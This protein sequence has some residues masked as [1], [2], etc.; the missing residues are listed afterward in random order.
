MA[1]TGSTNYVIQRDNLVKASLRMI[2]VGSVD[3]DPTSAEITN[4]VEALNIMLK[5]WQTA[6][7]QLW[8]VKEYE[9]TPVEGTYKYSLG[10]TNPAGNPVGVRPMRI[11]DAYRRDTSDVTD[12]PLRKMG[13]EEYWRLSDKDT[14]G[15]PTQFYYDNQ[16][17]DG[18][19]NIWPAPDASFASNNTI[20]ILYQKPF[21][22]MD[23][24]STDDFEFPSE[25]YEAIKYGL[26][27]RLAPE[28]MVPLQTRRLLIQEAMII[29][30]EVMGWDQEDTSVYLSPKRY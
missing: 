7:M 9:L 2:G 27:V 4:A 15:T 24:D 8:M 1:L 26:A 11:L 25:W 12:T 28:Y 6:G 3:E 29:K 5:A 10:E 23:V 30:D 16:L 20:N 13:R 14:K 17:D 19:F 18:I 22:D 21:D